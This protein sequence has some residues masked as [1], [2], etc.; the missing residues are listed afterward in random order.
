MQLG[1]VA[2]ALDLEA[3]LEAVGDALDH[4]GD[5]RARQP[6][7]RAVLAAV[8]RARD[9]SVAARR[10]ARRHR[11]VAVDALGQ[12]ALGAVDGHELGLDRDGHAGG[13]GDGLS[14]D[15]GHALLWVYQTFATTS[16]PTP[17]CGPRGR[18]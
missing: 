12:L 4:V 17:A 7:Q 15:T 2:D 9:E 18:S 13:D 10:P 14:A 11:D 8:G 1:A 5:E 6:V 3:L 16:P